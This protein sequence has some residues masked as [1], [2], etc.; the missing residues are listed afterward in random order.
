VTHFTCVN[1]VCTQNGTTSC[2]NYV[3]CG[4]PTACATTCAGD[5]NCISTAFCTG[6]GG[7]CMPKV[8]LGGACSGEGK[9]DHECLSPNVCSWA[10]D[11]K[12]GFCLASRCTGCQAAVGGANAGSYGCIDWGIDPRSVCT[13]RDSCHREWCDGCAANVPQDPNAAP[14]ACD[15]GF[16][17][18]GNW[19]PCG[20]GAACASYNGYGAGKL[21]GSLC[22]AS[23]TCAAN[24]STV[25]ADIYRG[26]YKCN[27]TNNGCD[28]SQFLDYNM[29]N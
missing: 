6:N 22:T 18:A 21:T 19:R 16:D 27:S 17:K 8:G 13:Y 12:S 25:C 4:S 28:Y 2:G 10:H 29:C 3:T 20:T 5:P 9:G 26:C 14:P 24:Q 11:G 1:K 7:T 23:G 15:S